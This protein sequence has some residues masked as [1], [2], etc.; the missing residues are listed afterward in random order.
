MR[1]NTSSDGQQDTKRKRG[2]LRWECAP[3]PSSHQVILSV[4]R[5]GSCCGAAHH[6]ARQALG[7]TKLADSSQKTRHDAFAIARGVC[8]IGTAAHNTFAAPSSSSSQGQSSEGPNLLHSS[9]H[10]ARPCRTEAC[11]VNGGAVWDSQAAE[12]SAGR[13]SLAD[14]LAMDDSR[15]HAACAP[16]Q[17]E[18]CGV[19]RAAQGVKAARPARVRA[20]CGVGRAAKGAKGHPR[21][22]LG[23]MLDR[24]AFRYL[25]CACPTCCRR[26]ARAGHC[27]DTPRRR[28]SRPHAH[29]LAAG[30]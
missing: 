18:G 23:P 21:G 3:P 1:A 10:S 19:G 27:A 24:Q 16:S 6:Q 17:A 26:A 22:T 20:G 5:A 25:W 14:K 15:V 12:V 7:R 9:I 13:L 2:V 29:A 11:E 8:D 4:S 30:E 28:G